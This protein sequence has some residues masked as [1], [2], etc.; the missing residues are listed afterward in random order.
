MIRLL[1]HDDVGRLLARR[2]TRLAEAEAV[3]RPIL[4]AVRRRGDRALMEYAR[5]F[6]GLAR[7]NVRVPAS[8]L[9]DALNSLSP[10]FTSAVK[11][12]AANVGAYALLQMPREWTKTR[13]GMRL[14]QIVRPLDTVAAYVPG[15]RYPL[16]STVGSS[17]VPS[18][19][20]QAPSI[21][22][23]WTYVPLICPGPPLLMAKPPMLPLRTVKP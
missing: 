23:V 11:E 16:P 5:K 18:N 7:K 4:D 9:R 2:K 8:E 15:G 12:A 10:A 13:N 17:K 19:E 22:P 21:S 1:Q 3:V 14:G 20:L 6:D